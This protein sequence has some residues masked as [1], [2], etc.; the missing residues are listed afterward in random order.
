M[1]LL[2]AAVFVLLLLKLVFPNP[3]N[4]LLAVELLEVLLTL[5][6]P[7][8]ANDIVGVVV[9]FVSPNPTVLPPEVVVVFVPNGLL[10]LLLLLLIL[11]V[12]NDALNVDDFKPAVLVLVFVRKL[13]SKSQQ[14]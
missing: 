8:P 1:G 13:I 2:T 12:C 11:F 14:Q 10:A 5:L 9:L 6:L 4:E 3:T 7:R